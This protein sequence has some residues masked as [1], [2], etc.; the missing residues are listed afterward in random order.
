MDDLL[1]ICPQPPYVKMMD[2]ISSNTCILLI[3]VS[4]ID[5]DIQVNFNR[6]SIAI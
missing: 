6:F 5:I 4:Y 3:K 1:N 2:E